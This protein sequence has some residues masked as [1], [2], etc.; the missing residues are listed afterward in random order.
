MK[1]PP[2]G[3]AFETSLGF[4]SH[5]LIVMQFEEHR[6]PRLSIKQA[7]SDKLKRG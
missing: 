6:R 4:S 1:K 2:A 5:V 3:E 7:R